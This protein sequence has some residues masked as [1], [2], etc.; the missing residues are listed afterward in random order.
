VIGAR[1]FGRQKE[2]IDTSSA[3]GELVFHVFAAIAHLERTLI[4]TQA[5][6]TVTPAEAA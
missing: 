1:M 3:A 5:K 4:S 2:K 6:R